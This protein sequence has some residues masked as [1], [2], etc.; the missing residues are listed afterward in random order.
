MVRL[1]VILEPEEARALAQWAASEMREPREQ[2]RW[3]LCEALEQRGW[4][5]H[6]DTDSHDRSVEKGEDE[7]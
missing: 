2:L 5:A 7:R 1:Q 3:L 6:A 4:L